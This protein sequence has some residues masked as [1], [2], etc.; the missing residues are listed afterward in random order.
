MP[1]GNLIEFIAGTSAQASEVNYNFNLV[2]SF[3][4]SL[5]VSVTDVTNDIA[6][7]QTQKANT[8]GDYRVRFAVADALNNYDAVNLQTLKKMIS[9]SVGYIWGL[10]ITRVG[11]TSIQVAA[12]TCYDSTYTKVLRLSSAVSKTNN[13]QAAS[14]TY[15]VYIIGTESG[16]TDILISASSNNPPLPT[17][18][19]SFRRIGS[20]VTNSSNSISSVTNSQITQSSNGGD[21]INQNETA[22]CNVSFPNL[23]R[24]RGIATNKTVK[25]SEAGWL[26]CYY[27]GDGN[28]FQVWVNNQELW[29]AGAWGSYSSH[30]GRSTIPIPRGSSIRSSGGGQNSLTFYPAV[31]Y[32]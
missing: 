28:G 27:M 4:D 2:K 20:Y 22:I 3:V 21:F 25:I 15:Y 5:E 24:G 11:N 14:T 16:S 13:N 32:T 1:L 6:Q 9:N 19:T 18:Y 8:N 23:S 31:A 10:G 7:I 30:R 29:S 26:V 17:N 12:G